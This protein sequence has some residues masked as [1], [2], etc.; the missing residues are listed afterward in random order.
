MIAKMLGAL[1]RSWQVHPKKLVAALIKGLENQSRTISGLNSTTVGISCQ[2]EP[3]EW[4]AEDY[5][6]I[7]DNITGKRLSLEA[8]QIAM[9]EEVEFMDKLA[10]LKEVPVEQSW[11]ETNAKPIEIKWI[12]TNKGDG[13]PV[14]SM[15]RLVATEL[16]VHQVKMGILRDNVFSATPP[17]ESRATLDELGVD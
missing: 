5:E 1:Q 17:L 8:V 6:N 2:E 14:E 10:V 16:E 3:I 7:C 12:Y 11:S 13:D 4:T 15:S 9:R